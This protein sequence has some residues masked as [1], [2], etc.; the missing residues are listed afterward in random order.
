MRPVLDTVITEIIGIGLR[1]ADARGRDLDIEGNAVMRGIGHG[2][3]L[4]GKLQAKLGWGIRAAGPAHQGIDM[5]GAILPV[6]QHP[7]MGH[8][9]AGLASGF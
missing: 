8:G 9:L 6:I 3:V 5:A 2:A 1:A 7:C 4:I